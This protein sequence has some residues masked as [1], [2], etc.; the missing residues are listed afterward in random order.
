MAVNC[1]SRP[2]VPSF[3]TEQAHEL[4]ARIVG[5]QRTDEADE[6]AAEIVALCDALPLAIRTVGLRLAMRPHGKLA[7]PFILLERF[8]PR[9]LLK[10]L[11]DTRAP[12]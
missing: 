10:V 1:W 12:P 7:H 5:R 8:D 11:R 4:R 2:G 6:A 3:T 9:P